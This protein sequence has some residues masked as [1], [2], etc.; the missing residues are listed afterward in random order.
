M[1][2]SGENHPLRFLRRAQYFALAEERE[3]L[4][5]LE[6]GQLSRSTGKLVKPDAGPPFAMF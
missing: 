5:T 2:T 6:Q 1:L 4:P 3:G